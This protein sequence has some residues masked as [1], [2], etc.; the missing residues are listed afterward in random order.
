[1]ATNFVISSAAAPSRSLPNCE[2]YKCRCSKHDRM[3]PIPQIDNENITKSSSDLTN[4]KDFR[5]FPSGHNDNNVSPVI[6]ANSVANRNILLPSSLSIPININNVSSKSHFEFSPI[7]W[8]NYWD[9]EIFMI[10]STTHVSSTSSSQS[11]PSPLSFVESI[12][13]QLHLEEEEEFSE[14]CP[15]SAKELEALTKNNNNNNN[16]N[17]SYLFNSSFVEDNKTTAVKLQQAS[18]SLKPASSLPSD[19]IP[20]TILDHNTNNFNKND[21]EKNLNINNGNINNNE[22]V[23]NINDN[24]S[25]IINLENNNINTNKNNNKSNSENIN[26][27]TSKKSLNNNTNP[28]KIVSKLTYKNSS[29]SLCSYSSDCSYSYTDSSSSVLSSSIV[30][31]SESESPRRRVKDSEGYIRRAA[32]VCVDDENESQVSQ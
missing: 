12:S 27:I 11:P 29:D 31:S 15:T 23:T 10:N 4:N 19:I 3:S 17:N 1:M 5:N 30:S 13:S 2:L 24:L 32:C 18:P 16:N 22:K 21:N 20:S 26:E 8:D 9:E 25:A 7:A 6:N 28:V 14:A